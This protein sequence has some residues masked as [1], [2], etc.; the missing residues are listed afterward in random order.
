MDELV[1]EGVREWFLEWTAPT[2]PPT[3]AGLAQ[4]RLCVHGAFVH[5]DSCLLAHHIVGFL[6]GLDATV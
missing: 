3:D 5:S 6:G 1:S 2:H 4:T